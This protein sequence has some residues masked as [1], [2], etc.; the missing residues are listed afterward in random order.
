[1]SKIV[2]FIITLAKFKKRR[3]RKF[4]SVKIKNKK[5]LGEDSLLVENLKNAYETFTKISFNYVFQLLQ[6]ICALKL[7]YMIQCD[8][9][10]VYRLFSHLLQG[11]I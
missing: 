2:F 11:K 3:Q 9:K 10:Y 5:E 8:L 1:M 7:A 4:L 6:K